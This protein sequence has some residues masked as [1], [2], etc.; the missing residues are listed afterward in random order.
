MPRRHTY[1]DEDLRDAVR[2]SYSIA[3]VLRHLG[4]I[5][6]GGNYATVKRKIRDLAIDTSHFL[7]QSIWRGKPSVRLGRFRM[8]LNQLLVED[9]S[10]TSTWR[11]KLRLLR[12]GVKDNACEF[13]GL[14]QWMGKPIPLE[15]H[16]INGDRTDCRID[17]IQLL[18]P[19]CHAL[20]SNYRGKNKRASGYA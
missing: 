12:E 19:N 6:A 4:L 7:G 18:C 11:L 20:T 14:E 9:S 15:L 8:S 1:T 2:N 3:Q 10:C 17:N 13:C 16:H 5:E